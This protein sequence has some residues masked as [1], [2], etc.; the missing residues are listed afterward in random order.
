[1]HYVLKTMAG[2]RSAP[3][4]IASRLP[5]PWLAQG[6]CRL[7]GPAGLNRPSFDNTCARVE[8]AGMTVMNTRDRNSQLGG[9]P[10]R[11]RL[12]SGSV[13]KGLDQ[14]RARARFTESPC[15]MRGPCVLNV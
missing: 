5:L 14:V 15:T 10:L 7:C 1:M 9:E 4:L 12:G 6:D 2:E 13:I 8:H 11:F 3:S